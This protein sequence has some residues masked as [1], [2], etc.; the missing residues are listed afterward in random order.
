MMQLESPTK[1]KLL[2]TSNASSVQVADKHLSKSCAFHMLRILT[3]KKEKSL[4]KTNSGI[5]Y[6][7][8][9]KKVF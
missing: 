5:S 6:D 7:N 1:F 9:I 2:I 4:L 8:D 3:P